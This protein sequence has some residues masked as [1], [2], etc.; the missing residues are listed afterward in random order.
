MSA[1]LAL[2]WSTISKIC[3]VAP[4]DVGASVIRYNRLQIDEWVASL[5]PKAIKNAALVAPTLPDLE[6]EREERRNAALDKV[7]A[8]TSLHHH[9]RRPR[10]S[11]GGRNGQG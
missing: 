8:R 7:R 11:D 2:S 10:L 9:G 6:T 5:P 4:V 1:Y 3:T